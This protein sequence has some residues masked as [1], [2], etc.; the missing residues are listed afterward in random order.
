[1]PN[2]IEILAQHSAQLVNFSAIGSSLGLDRKT[3]DRY[4]NLLTSM[5]LVQTVRPWFRNHL[6][7]LIK[8]PKLHFIDTGLLAME[9]GVTSTALKK[10]R[11]PWGPL[12][13][14]FVFAE[15]LKQSSWAEE[16]HS[17]F[18]YRDKD[19]AEVDFVVENA[20][21][22]VIGVEV[23]VA[24]TVRSADFNGLRRLKG[25]VGSKQFKAGLVLYDGD[26]ILPFEPNLWA[27]P[28]STLWS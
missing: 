18:H 27:A 9:Q 19:Q 10:D 22:D 8:T 11:A 12:L 23:K 13:E 6:K 5:F 14:S 1:V 16:R 26:Q 3:A 4:V 2:L 28:I 24:A 17:I 7:R 20:S 25:A 15:L 21:R